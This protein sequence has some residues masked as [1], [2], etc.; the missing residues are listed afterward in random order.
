MP[1][2]LQPTPPTE[3]PIAVDIAAADKI[4]AMRRLLA[5]ASG[6]LRFT[7]LQPEER[8]RAG[9]TLSAAELRF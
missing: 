1:A 7:R 5:E 8:Q 9:R 2:P 3:P 6:Q 4:R